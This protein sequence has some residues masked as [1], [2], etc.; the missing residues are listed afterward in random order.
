MTELDALRTRFGALRSDDVAA[1]DRAAVESGVTVVQLM[2]IAGF[3]VARCAWALI[4]ERPDSVAVIAG[5]GNNGGD[6]L[7]AARHLATWGCEV[8][9]CVLAQ[10]GRLDGL[11]ATHAESARRNGVVV[12]TSLAIAD[13]GATVDAAALVLDAVLGTGLRAAPREPQAAAVRAMNASAAR[14]LAID[15]PSGMDASTGEVFDPCVRAAATCTLAAVKAGLWTAAAASVAG[16]LWVADIAMPGAAWRACGLEQP[17][18]IHAG[19]LLPVPSA[20]L[21]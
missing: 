12:R 6:G 4:G 9:A 13:V 1:L 20:T 19:A 11:I 3:Q 18:N 8:R 14:I 15:V 2:E 21:Y 7:V 10:P 17:T 5:H 16:A